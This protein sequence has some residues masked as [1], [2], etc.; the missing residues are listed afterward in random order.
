MKRFTLVV[1]LGAAMIVLGALPTD[2]QARR[3]RQAFR[4]NPP[5]VNCGCPAGTRPACYYQ[6]RGGG[7]SLGAPD[8]KC[9]CPKTITT[10]WGSGKLIGLGCAQY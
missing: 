2:A 6:M 1:I 10:W 8:D 9:H 5:R 4:A 3:V 7:V